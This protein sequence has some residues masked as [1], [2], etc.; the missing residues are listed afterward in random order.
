MSSTT[1]QGRDSVRF[2]TSVGPNSTEVLN[3]EVPEDVTVERLSVRIYRGA[4]LELRLS[5]FVDRDRADDRERREPLVTFEG[6]QYIDGDD[7]FFEFDL[8]I[9]VEEGQEI[10]VEVENLDGTYTYNFSAIVELDSAGGLDRVFNVIG[11][12]L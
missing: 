1:R 8:A 11:G 9:P 6:K 5:P 2:A 10:G 4:E 7:D 12:L 3:Y